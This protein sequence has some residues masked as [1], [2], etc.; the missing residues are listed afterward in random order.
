MNSFT[1]E[2]LSCFLT[3]SKVEYTYNIRQ[4][5]KYENTIFQL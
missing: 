1:C 3:Q 5:T 2:C 4:E